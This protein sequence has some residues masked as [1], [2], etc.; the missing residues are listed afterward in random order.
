M[1]YFID[2]LQRRFRSRSLQTIRGLNLIAPKLTKYVW[3]LI[4]LF[5]GFPLTA[6]FF[7][8]WDLVA[9]LMYTNQF[10]LL[11]TLL[12]VNVA[13]TLFFCKIMFSIIYG[14]PIKATNDTQF[15]DIQKKEEG[16]LNYLSFLI[17]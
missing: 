3:F 12:I 17:F 10:V 13:G 4:F 6:K 11:I 15:L 8:E 16:V 7:I 2:I 14:T 1:F 5:S 9:L